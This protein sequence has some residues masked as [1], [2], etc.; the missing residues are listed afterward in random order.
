MNVKGAERISFSVRHAAFFIF[1]S[2]TN[3]PLPSSQNPKAHLQKSTSWSETIFGPSLK[4][5]DFC[6]SRNKITHQISYH[7]DEDQKYET[8]FCISD[9][10]S[11]ARGCV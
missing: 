2:P 1:I 11:V 6:H 9:D 3:S 10:V 4:S 8:T 5:L 7:P